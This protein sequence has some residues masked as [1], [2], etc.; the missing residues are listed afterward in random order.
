MT[1]NNKKLEEK[2]KEQTTIFIENRELFEE[3][4][5][6]II[7]TLSDFARTLPQAP[8][9]QGRVKAVDSFVEK[10]IR[11]QY[12]YHSPAWQLTDLCGV[13]VIVLSKES[14]SR[15][16]RM[17]EN[18][19][20]VTEEEDTGGR[21]SETE[22]GYQSV[23]YIVSLDPA[24]KDTNTY[25]SPEN[26][27]VL[28]QLFSSRTLEEAAQTGLAE[29][30]VFKAEIQIRTLL[31]HAWSS[32]VHDNIYKTDMRTTPRH[33]KRRA[34]LIAA[35]IEDTD[36][37]ILQLLEG[38]E[39]YRS[40]YGA[41]MSPAKMREEIAMQRIVLNHNPKARKAALK[42]A[43]LANCLNDD[44]ELKRAEKDLARLRNDNDSELLRELG[45]IR[46]KLGLEEE[47]RSNL[48][49]AAE[50]DRENADTWC[51][52]GKTYFEKKEYWEAQNCYRKAFHADP[53]YP[54]ALKRLIECGILYGK[55]NP[56][57]LLLLI[58]PN[59]GRAIELS[60]KKIRAG[61]H[62][63]YAWY[64]IGFFYLLLNQPGKSLDAYARGVLTTTAPD[65]VRITYNALTEIHKKVNKKVTDRFS[66]LKRG[67]LL[68]R[69]FFRLILAEKF[70]NSSEQY[71]HDCDSRL[72]GFSSLSPSR[73]DG[74]ANPLTG[75]K[76]LILA[77]GSCSQESEAFMSRYKP[78]LHRA[79][80]GFQ[81]IV[82]CGGTDA[83]ISGIIGGLRENNPGI[84]T[85]GYLPSKAVCA[86][87]YQCVHTVS[88]PFSPLD[89]IMCWAD[90]LDSGR[91]PETVS[92]LGV[93]GGEISAFELQLGLL[94][95]AKVGILPDS[96]GACGDMSC[97][98]DWLTVTG[99]AEKPGKTRLLKLP[100]DPET[101]RAFLQPSATSPAL[102]D[103]DT[104]EKLA[105]EIHESYRQQEKERLSGNRGAMRPWKDLDATF[106]LANFKQVDQIE[107]KL[108]RLG[109][110]LKK[111]QGEG[112]SPY[113][114]SPSQLEELA[115]MEH[116]RWVVERLEDG[117][118]LG[119]SNDEKKTRPQ[120][121][122][123]RE[124]PE[125]ER[126]KDYDTIRRL[127]EKLAA[128]GLQIVEEKNR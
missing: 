118:T 26:S 59:L 21:L 101:V 29:G 126:E 96:G 32:T 47:G 112:F 20:L 86:E 71:L 13:R 84:T 22:F 1:D 121:V 30:P 103:T 14:I 106:R 81:G 49:R 102:I 77:A 95:G 72:D 58:T 48:K 117:W 79:F 27:T 97:D 36:N 74:R 15:F 105:A 19:F 35:L 122:P 115:E 56:L 16:R 18:C 57:E 62:I 60:L 45:A 88:G 116:G 17:I 123:W 69:S 109:L 50:L 91:D 119:E 2:I 42:I 4:G 10:C 92:L 65:Q 46:W 124:L 51:E 31:Q 64:D 100:E 108:Q 53:Q 25:C 93:R 61:M 43:R 54:R 78:L 52:L 33:L 9:I 39:E 99:P 104:R 6:V 55:D 125:E 41:Y 120:L 82:C 114:F 68:V 128:A 40:Y 23:H 85:V 127:P 66:D 37:S 8:I 38:V 83:G 28:E 44:S 70:K 80:A 5:R 107:A 110:T 63:P 67:L 94:L 98:P 11:K 87:N 12:K 76:K 7:S 90:I 34:S 24:G 73:R 111:Q 89:A 3:L 75:N 113:C